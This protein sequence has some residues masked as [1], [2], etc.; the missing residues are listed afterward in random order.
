MIELSDG[1]SS[2]LSTASDHQ[3]AS[4]SCKLKEA[5]NQIARNDAPHSAIAK[6]R[7]DMMFNIVNQ[8]K[9]TYRTTKI[10]RSAWMFVDGVSRNTRVRKSNSMSA[11][12]RVFRRLTGD[13]CR[14]NQTSRL[15]RQHSQTWTV[16]FLNGFIYLRIIEVI[17]WIQ[18]CRHS[19]TFSTSFSRPL[20]TPFPSHCHQG[21]SFGR[22]WR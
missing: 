13:T 16:M 17:S 9:L 4:D 3:I 6:L 8:C 14:P 15:Q 20:H 2:F 5:T 22:W 19:S 18:R 21:W 10:S 12:R 11:R 1:V 7:R